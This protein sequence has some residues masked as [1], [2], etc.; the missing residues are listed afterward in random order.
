MLRWVLIA[1]GVPCLIGAVILVVAHVTT[2]LVT[3]LA[4]NGLLIA[5]AILFERSSYRSQVNR[6]RTYGRLQ[7]NSS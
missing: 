7:A 3:Y 5:G 6:M 1:Y 4:I 2:A